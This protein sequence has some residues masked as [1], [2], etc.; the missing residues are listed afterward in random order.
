MWLL[1]IGS[2]LIYYSYSV[3]EVMNQAILLLC[4]FSLKNS[5][6]P[7]LGIIFNSK[8]LILNQQC[9]CVENLPGTMSQKTLM[10][11]NRILTFLF[12]IFTLSLFTSFLKFIF[13]FFCNVILVSIIPY[14]EIWKL[15]WECQSKFGRKKSG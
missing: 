12:Y 9:G 8:I 7:L 3:K 14:L 15:A 13:V 6:K 11:W 2:C 1:I 10:K 4:K 5:D